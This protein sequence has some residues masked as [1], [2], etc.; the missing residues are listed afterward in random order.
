MSRLDTLT[1][2][3]DQGSMIEGDLAVGLIQW[4]VEAQSHGAAD[5]KQEQLGRLYAALGQDRAVGE[6]ESLI[7]SRMPTFVYF[8]DYYRVRPR[9][10]LRQLAA[11]VDSGD[12]DLA[13]DFGSLCLLDLLG[14]GAREL[15]DMGKVPD[16]GVSDIESQRL[17]QDQLDERTY[18]LNAA[19]VELTQFVRRVWGDDDVD[20]DIRVDQDY[21]KVIC[22][23][24]LGVEIELDQRSE[25]F[26]WL[27]SFY[28][29][30]KSQASR[31]LSN[32]ILLLDDPG[33]NLHALKQQEFRRTVSALAAD[34]QTIYTTH[35][36]F[37]VGTDELDMIR[38]IDMKSREVGTQIHNQLV[39]DDPAA[40]FPL[41]AALGYAMSESLFANRRNL[42][43]EGITEFLYVQSIAEAL[44]ADGVESLDEEIALLPAGDAGKLV[45]LSGLLQSQESAVAALVDSDQATFQDQFVALMTPKRIHRIKDFYSGPVGT[46]EIED[47]LRETLVSVAKEDRDWDVKS[48][49]SKEPTRPIG[50]IFQSEVDD[51]SRYLLARR[52]V[53]WL[54]VNGASALRDQERAEWSQMFVEINRSLG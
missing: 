37:M 32:A 45:Y 31:G 42:V 36:P 5:A 2:P 54:T 6:A 14:L 27:T 22:R 13:Y 11:A 43:L 44:R 53:R 3:L 10:H 39:A 35:S 28:V 47:L 25:G 49:A 38:V 26:Q 29:V 8:S 19:S 52:F 12:T 34:N 23:D 1:Q 16:P 41:R 17:A 15:S 33:V 4:L 21:L 51:F 50:E 18:R 30:F 48:R 9:V 40:L 20:I 46:P 7:L 24:S